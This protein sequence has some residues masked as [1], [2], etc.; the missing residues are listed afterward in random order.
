MSESVAGSA[1]RPVAAGERSAL[2]PQ[3]LV[4]WREP[5]GILNLRGDPRDPGLR[6]AVQPVMGAGLPPSP[7]GVASG[8]VWRIGAAGP[9]DWFLIGPAEGIGPMADAMTRA[10]RGLNT[11][12]TDVSSGYRLLHLSEPGAVNLLAQGCPLDLHPRVFR[13]GQCAGSHFFKASVWLWR[14]GD[15][16][17]LLVRRSFQGYVALMLTRAAGSHQPD[18][19]RAATAC[20]MPEVP[21]PTGCAARPPRAPAR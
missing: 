16:I 2:V 18:D 1:S 12:L 5:L 14:T 10:L 15:G 17:E 9:D 13:E 20:L 6:A 19:A 11:A 4:H 7:G 3:P 21:S 8:S